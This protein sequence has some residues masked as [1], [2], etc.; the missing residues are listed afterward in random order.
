M[1]AATRPHE[2]SGGPLHIQH[3]HDF[4][5]SECATLNSNSTIGAHALARLAGFN[6]LR[7]ADETGELP[8]FCWSV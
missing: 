3:E 1:V 8:G 4:W 2:V 7:A 6:S 5:S